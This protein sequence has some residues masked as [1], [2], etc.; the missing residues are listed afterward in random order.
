MWVRVRVHLVDAAQAELGV[1]DEA[2]A[3][4][5]ERRRA[6]AAGEACAGTQ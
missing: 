5:E 2:A 1:E 3:A 6:E 4:F